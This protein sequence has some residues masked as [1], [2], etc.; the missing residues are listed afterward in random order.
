MPSESPAE[1]PP[2]AEILDTEALEAD[3][4]ELWR[5]REIADG[6]VRLTLWYQPD[7]LNIRRSVIERSVPPLVSDS[8]QKLVFAHRREADEREGPWSARLDVSGEA[9]GQVGL[10][11]S[12]SEYCP[13][14][15]RGTPFDGSIQMMHS[16][17]PQRFGGVR[18]RTIGVR[19]WTDE[20][21]RVERARQ[22]SGVIV[23]GT[24]MDR[25]LTEFLRPYRFE[26][27]TLDGVPVPGVLRIPVR[28]RV[29]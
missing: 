1:L 18:T 13:P 24:D 3:V 15:P 29:P 17:R 10:S 5:A 22:A 16:R 8:V 2:A 14:T 20:H 7:G 11:V 6:H 25:R 26:P 27:A 21:G 9:S 4:G 23:G 19:V 28:V 12:R